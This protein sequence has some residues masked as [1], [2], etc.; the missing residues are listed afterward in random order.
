[1]CSNIYEPRVAVRRWER[2]GGGAARASDFIEATFI[3]ATR[4][5]VI[6][7]AAQKTEQSHE[8]P[9]D[10]LAGRRFLAVHCLI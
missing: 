1:V 5:I 4:V 7:T 9:C 3:A 2:V 10:V 8:C 6:E